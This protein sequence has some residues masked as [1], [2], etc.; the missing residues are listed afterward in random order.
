MIR[1]L[2]VEDSVTQR[3]ILRKMIDSTGQIV[4]I[5]EARNGKEAVDA[6]SRVQ[7]DVVLMDIHMPDMDGVTATREIMQRYPVPIV[8]VS[9]SLKARDV[10]LGME[11]LK[12]G[13][14]SVMEK[15]QGSVLL[16]LDKMAADVC[17]Q[18]MIASKA[19]VRPR[20]GVKPLPPRPSPVQAPS[21]TIDI[22]GICAS[23]GGPPVLLHILSQIPKPYP[24]PVLLVQHIAEGFVEGFANWLAGASGQSVHRAQGQRPVTPGFWLSPGNLHLGVTLQRR[25]DLTPPRARE[26]HCPS[27]NAL[28]R[29]LAT[30]CGPRALG[31]LLT[32]MGDDGADGLLELHRAGGKTIVQDEESSLI[33]GMPKAGIERGGAE[34]QLSPDGIIDLLTE[35]ANQGERHGSPSA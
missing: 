29:S 13:A 26:I 30:N 18:L 12:A 10:D 34:V 33:Y 9:A 35:I 32:G 2:L 27:G 14:V 5:A 3:E 15:P 22:V 20:R 23:T 11:A 25:F 1:L 16:H 21:R 19:R 31:I 28:F 8:V 7:P 17:Q 24:L 4:V 6:V